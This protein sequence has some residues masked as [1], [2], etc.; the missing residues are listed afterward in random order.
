[1]VTCTAPERQRGKKGLIGGVDGEL[2]FAAVVKMMQTV[3]GI[4]MT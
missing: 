1:M 3:D 4:R 2:T